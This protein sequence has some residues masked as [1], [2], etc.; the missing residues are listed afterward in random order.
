MAS[1]VV[2]IGVLGA[3]RITPW[4]L[5]APAQKTPRVRVVAIAARDRRRAERFAQK[6]AI[7][8]VY[9]DYASLIASS[10]V[11]AI[12]NPLPNC[13]HCCWSV[14]ALRAGKHV[15]CEKPLAANAD[16]ARTMAAAADE[17]GLVLMDAAHYRYH[18]LTHRALELLGEGAIGVLRHVETWMCVPL[19]APGNIRYNFELAGGAAMDVGFY[20]NHMALT[21]AGGESRVVA[22]RA[23]LA[24][25][26]VD[27]RM[28]TELQFD[29]GVTART[30]C[31]LWSYQLL[32]MAVRLEGTAGTIL[33]RGPAVP[34]LYHRLIVKTAKGIRREKCTRKPTYAF[35]LDA[36]VASVL[37]GAP[38]RTDAHGAVRYLSLIDACYQKAGL[39]VRPSGPL[40]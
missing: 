24:K 10:E 36:F 37:D 27:R 30:H 11:D 29:N 9:D 5:I 39:P 7:E 18:P 38:V 32:K 4:A 6:H 34:Q 28:D 1:D 16:E 31:S 17:T 12:Y 33:V 14:R 40:P 8:H 25:A 35:Q 3:A 13:L 21:Y 22:A 15:L 19:P 20:A 26:N 23:K 2:R